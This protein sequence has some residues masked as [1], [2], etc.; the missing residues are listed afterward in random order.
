MVIAIKE[1][2]DGTTHIK[3]WVPIYTGFEEKS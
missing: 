1:F 3:H 2:T